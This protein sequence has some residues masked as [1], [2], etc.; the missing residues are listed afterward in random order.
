MLHRGAD[1]RGY[2]HGVADEMY[3]SALQRGRVRADPL[4][5]LPMAPGPCPVIRG[6]MEMMTR[7]ATLAASNEV[8][9]RGRAHC[10]LSDRQVVKKAMIKLLYKPV[11]MLV[12]VL[13]GYL[14]G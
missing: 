12:S 9:T 6:A 4:P 1:V 8:M 14:P 3:R 2:D 13:A 11:G 10:R 7:S 5:R